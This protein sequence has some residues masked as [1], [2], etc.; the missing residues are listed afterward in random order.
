MALPKVWWLDDT[1]PISAKKKLAAVRQQL[2]GWD[3]NRF[4][5]DQY[6]S[7]KDAFFS[8]CEW[9]GTP[10]MF[11]TGKVVY[12]YGIPFKKSDWANKLA[13]EFENI[14]PSVILIII[15]KPDKVSPLYKKVQSMVTS[16]TGRADEAF[17]FDRRPETIAWIR[18][19]AADLGAKI[20]EDACAMLADF[21]GFNPTMICMELQKLRHF[22]PDGRITAQV[23]ESAAF[24]QTE[25]DVRKVADYVLADDPDMAHEF[26]QRLLDRG[27]DP[28]KICGF[29]QDWAVKMALAESA[30]CNYES[31]KVKVAQ[32]LKW[33]K[34]AKKSVPMYAKPGAVYHACTALSS[35]KK[36]PFWAFRGLAQM[37]K[38][39]LS[40]RRGED[41]TRAMHEYI[42]ALIQG[43]TDG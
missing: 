15:A 10:S 43:K 27:E 33:D 41:G 9:L 36:K 19:R 26:V 39:Q 38:L 23:V 37:G 42:Q 34:E 20:D 4:V 1:D 28:L 16:K 13:E 18:D 8:I 22:A 17:E 40:L 29:M 25:A 2:A 14:H 3:W 7:A 24:V 5:D 6:E 30:G 21:S 35:S 32:C 12:F 31:I 11:S